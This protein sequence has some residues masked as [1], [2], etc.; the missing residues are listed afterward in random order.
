MPKP[1]K[2][3]AKQ[4]SAHWMTL[5]EQ[6]Q[7][8]VA[9]GAALGDVESGLVFLIGVAL[10][11]QPKKEL[12]IMEQ[13]GQGTGSAH[14]FRWDRVEQLPNQ[15]VFYAGGRIAFGIAPFAEWMELDQN[16]CQET[17][18][19]WKNELAAHRRAYQRFCRNEFRI[20]T[21]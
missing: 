19:N 9:Q 17:F 10:V 16:T 20:L 1:K 12:L 11:R 5:D 14:L 4:D 3:P 8:M 6:I 15:V 21:A 2:R 13:W 18:I 7:A